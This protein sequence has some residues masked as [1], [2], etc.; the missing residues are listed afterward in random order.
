MLESPGDL[1]LQ[2]ESGTADLVVGVVIEDLL[3]G[4]HGFEAAVL[5]SASGRGWMLL[6]IS[7]RCERRCRRPEPPQADQLRIAD[8]RARKR[9]EGRL[10]GP[11]KLQR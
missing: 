1:G 11:H 7:D 10:S 5:L 9:R 6:P 2:E 8:R 4:D 3:E